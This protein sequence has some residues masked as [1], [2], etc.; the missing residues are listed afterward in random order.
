MS[1]SDDS[2]ESVA[3]IMAAADGLD[4]DAPYVSQAHGCA[5]GNMASQAKNWEMFKTRAREA[6]FNETCLASYK[7]AMPAAERNN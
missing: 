3:R 2:I 1:I 6:L 7:A 4:G 5:I